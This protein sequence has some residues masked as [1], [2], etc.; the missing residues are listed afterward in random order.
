MKRITL[1][2][3]ILI[4]SIFLSAC[5][6]PFAK[7]KKSGLQ[8][9]TDGSDASVFLNGAYVEKTPFIDR[10]LSPGEY[11]LKIQPDNPELIPYENTI[12]LRP[13]LLTV[14]TWKLASRP[15]YSGGV[16][17]EMEPI[18]S[19]DTSELSFITIPDGAIVAI[20]GQEKQFS[21]VI[22]PGI[23]PGHTEFEVSLPSYESQKHT[24]NAVAGYR[25]E[26]TVKLAKNKNGSDIE[27][28]AA[29][30]ASESATEVIIENATESSETIQATPSPTTTPIVLP[31]NTPKIRINP[32]NFFIDG[33]EVLRVRSLPSS[34]GEEL[35]FATVG[36]E[37]KYLENI[38]S[39]WY[40]I[41]FE[42]KSGWVSGQYAEL[43]E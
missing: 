14:V 15:E 25:M 28:A 5:T 22:L 1:L 41:D 24:I 26:V 20:Q 40:N 2:V 13:G 16:I 30:E 7:P 23:T 43:V 6:N 19:K 33:V 18:S 39:G 11:Y 9:I 37:Y 42:G 31:A 29:T 36:A 12:T 17:Y 34:Q 3:V 4:T 32:T 8:V 35:G 21:P 27:S 10:E 38:Q